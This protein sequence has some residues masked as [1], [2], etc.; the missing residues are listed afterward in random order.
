LSVVTAVSAQVLP[1]LV[2]VEY[3]SVRPH[4][5]Q[6]GDES[7]WHFVTC[8]G[9]AFLP[10]HFSVRA[11]FPN[12]IWDPKAG[13]LVNFAVYSAEDG[14]LTPLCSNDLSATDPG[15]CGF[16]HT[17]KQTDFYMRVQAPNYALAGQLVSITILSE[18]ATDSPEPIP[19]PVNDMCPPQFEDLSV[20]LRSAGVE[21]IDNAPFNWT[22]WAQYELPICGTFS[23]GVTF[24]AQ[25]ADTDSAMSSYLC[26]GTAGAPP[27]RADISFAFTSVGSAQNRI[28]VNTPITDPTYLAI[29]GWGSYGRSSRLLFQMVPN[30]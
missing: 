8:H 22:R 18:P 11:V 13:S 15:I 21:T 5:F 17:S 7:W 10:L 16:T 29:A 30:T 25:A 12:S 27:C 6:P 23:K 1:R 26:N 14:C 2:P 9:S 24:T 28:V 20:S 3:A 4:N 19:K